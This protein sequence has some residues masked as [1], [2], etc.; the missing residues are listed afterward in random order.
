MLD[1]KIS[2]L[3]IELN[4]FDNYDNNTLYQDGLVAL[5]EGNDKFSKY[6]THIILG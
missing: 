1:G 2:R 3:S 4:Y 6:I 5:Y